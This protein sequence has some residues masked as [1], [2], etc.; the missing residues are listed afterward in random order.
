M[1]LVLIALAATTL[2]GQESKLS[3]SDPAWKGLEVRFV[4][5]VE[6]P[7]DNARAQ[8]PGAIIGEKGRAHHLINDP[9]HKVTF[10]Y[11]LSLEPGDDGQT[12]QL[13]VEPMKTS[14]PRSYLQPGWT[15]LALPKY[16]VIPKVRVG[17]TVALDLLVNRVTGQ[18]IVDYLTVARPTEGPAH[19]FTLSDVNLNLIDPRV[20]VNGNLVDLTAKFQGG[21]AGPIVWLYLPGHGRFI[22]SLFPN[23]A[24]GF[25]KNGVAARDTLAFREG[26]AE[27]R[28][29]CSVPV[30]PGEGRY[31][32]YVVHEPEW[33]A[34]GGANELQVGSADKAEWVVGKH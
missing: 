13:R 22:L 1:K 17:E 21:T 27:Y 18:R 14:D 25:H 20:R 12:V 19:D 2:W 6:P 4:T 9:A 16:P 24:L 11:D 7:G 8:L 30:A 26:S 5:K 33:Q 23:D 29:T 10:G 34:Y 28:V 3:V 31:N 15:L 32:L